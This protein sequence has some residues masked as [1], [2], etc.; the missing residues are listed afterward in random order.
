LRFPQTDLEEGKLRP[1]LVLGKLPGEYGDWLAC[2]VTSQLR[3]LVAGFDEIVQETGDDFEDSGLKTASVIR[4]GRVAIVE[5]GI[6]VGAIG[7]ISSARLQR[8]REHLAA[9]LVSA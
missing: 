2:M 3:H 9:W 7:Q 8:T 4:V 5:G 6:L 1:V